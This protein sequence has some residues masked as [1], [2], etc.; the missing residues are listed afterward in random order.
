MPSFQIDSS[1]AFASSCLLGWISIITSSRSRRNFFAALG[2]CHRRQKST[3]SKLSFCQSSHGFFS[4]F[5]VYSSAFLMSV[6][7]L[8][9]WIFQR[10][11][12]D[13]VILCFWF[14][15]RF[16][17]KQ[18]IVWFLSFLFGLKFFCFLCNS[19][20]IFL[21]VSFLLQTRQPEFFC[22]Y[23]FRRHH[24]SHRFNIYI[25]IKAYL[26]TDIH[27]SLTQT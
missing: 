23:A 15:F 16:F 22:A 2:D 17:M 25:I 21:R 4:V 10:I 1:S 12:L 26:K 11:Q 27:F 6:A 9:W 3:A 8:R 19:L 7:F 14:L 24:K 20:G 5:L 18:V 13:V